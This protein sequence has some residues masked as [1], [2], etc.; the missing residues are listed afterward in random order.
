MKA[1]IASPPPHPAFLTS[2]QS[3]TQIVKLR[4][5]GGRDIAFTDLTGKTTCGYIN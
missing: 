5:E 2:S 3:A 4:A 1:Q